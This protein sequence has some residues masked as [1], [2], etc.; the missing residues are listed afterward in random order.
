MAPAPRWLTD[1]FFKDIIK[2]AI[3]NE[4]SIND[5]K[6]I[7]YILQKRNQNE[8]QPFKKISYTS[9][10]SYVGT[11]ITTKP[12]LKELLRKNMKL[13]LRI[14]D[15]QIQK[16][17]EHTFLTFTDMVDQL[18]GGDFNLNPCAR[19][20]FAIA[21]E[22]TSRQ[23]ELEYVRDREELPVETF[24]EIKKDIDFD[25]PISILLTEFC[26]RLGCVDD[27]EVYA[28]FDKNCK[29]KKCDPQLPGITIIHVYTNPM[30]NQ[31]FVKPI[32]RNK[33]WGSEFFKHSIKFRNINEDN[34]LQRKLSCLQKHA[35]NCD[36]PTRLALNEL[37]QLKTPYIQPRQKKRRVVTNIELDP[38]RD[39]EFRLVQQ[40]NYDNLEQGK[41]GEYLYISNNSTF[42]IMNYFDQEPPKKLLFC[43]VESLHIANKCK[44]SRGTEV[45]D[46]GKYDNDDY[47]RIV[48]NYQNSR[49]VPAR[50]C[51]FTFVGNP[52]DF[53]NY[54]ADHIKPHEKCNNYIHVENGQVMPCHEKTNLRWASTYTQNNNKSRNEVPDEF[55]D[56]LQEEDDRLNLTEEQEHELLS[57]IPNTIRQKIERLIPKYYRAILQFLNGKKLSEDDYKK[58]VESLPCVLNFDD[59]S[60]NVWKLY[61]FEKVENL[62]LEEDTQ[63][64]INY[65]QRKYTTLEC[66]M[67]VVYLKMK[68]FQNNIVR[69]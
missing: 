10:L 44:V 64:I 43:D 24:I 53:K 62:S 65:L 26:E 39:V 61:I 33:A 27:F 56:P 20:F 22:K 45:Y 47:K 28:V 30:T 29:Y 60:R 19:I 21:N 67:Q 35:V 57:N 16:I 17:Q 51:L 4:V 41:N 58:V 3:D 42:V 49:F 38:K 7:D 46:H 50:L 36:E 9:W 15:D 12:E 54:S 52:P 34:L 14:K 59:I 6:V 37:V 13:L 23:K 18:F 32:S 1:I 48:F 63:N 68:A 2:F 25:E 69:E 5:D 11:L 8:K 55:K 40:G 31:K 66:K